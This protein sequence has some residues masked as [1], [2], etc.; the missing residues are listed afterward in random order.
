ML[1]S[2]LFISIFAVG[3]IALGSSVI[4]AQDYPNR[5]IRIIT[6]N[7]GGTGDILS[8]LTAE[9]ISGPLGQPVIVENRGS[10]ILPGDHVAKAPPDGYTL[11]LYNAAVWTAQFFQKAPYDPV[12][13]FVP[14]SHL[15]RDS[16]ILAVQQSLC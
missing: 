4:G 3:T 7:V 2:R 5:P 13:D 14:I 15:S 1:G 16:Q 11:L 12:R 6:T 8:R 9:G 10:G